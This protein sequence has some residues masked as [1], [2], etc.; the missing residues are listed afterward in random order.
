MERE[1]LAYLYTDLG[2][3]D[4][5][6]ASF[7]GLD[8]TAVVHMRRRHR[9][10][11]RTSTGRTGELK[12]IDELEKRFGKKNVVDM[13]EEDATSDFDILLNDNIRIEVKSAKK[14][15]DR[16]RYYFAFSNS[17]ERRVKRT[18]RV[19]V[20]RTGKTIKDLSQSCDFVILVFLDG[21]ATDFLILPSDSAIIQN[22][23]TISLRGTGGY[24][25]YRSNWDLLTRG[26][27]NK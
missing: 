5:E 21:K 24:P 11:T 2:R 17:K 7:I 6:I 15:N 20:T 25:E 27:E 26:E 3:S 10:P 13:N 18:E 9:I 8:R 4:A 1:V 22:K 12:V 16:S 14:A 23:Q 19:K